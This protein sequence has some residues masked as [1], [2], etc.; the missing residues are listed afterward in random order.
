MR[1]K[2]DKI[3]SGECDIMVSDGYTGN[4]MLKTAEGMSDFITNNLKNVFNKSFKNQ[5]TYKI[6]TQFI[7]STILL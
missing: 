1:F 5:L 7:T 4:I 2:T 6:L 3:T